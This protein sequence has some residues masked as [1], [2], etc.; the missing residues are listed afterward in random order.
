[1]IYAIWALPTFFFLCRIYLVSCAVAL[2]ISDVNVL[3]RFAIIVEEWD[4]CPRNAPNPVNGGC[5]RMIFVTDAICQ[6][7]SNG[8][9]PFI[10]EDMYLRGN[11]RG[12]R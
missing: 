7:I 1:M 8:I 3:R 9:V 10:G 4:T 5:L 12:Q 11:L 2:T 6:A